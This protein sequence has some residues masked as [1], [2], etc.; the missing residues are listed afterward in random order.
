LP[1]F[2]YTQP[3][4]VA[5]QKP[6]IKPSLSTTIKNGKYE[7]LLAYIQQGGRVKGIA[8]NKTQIGELNES[9]MII[10]IFLKLLAM[11]A[12][13]EPVIHDHFLDSWLP[14]PQ[15]DNILRRN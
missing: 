4:Q 1:F 9:N 12:P 5:Q 13:Y 10:H 8:D 15:Q 3:S 7:E 14:V 11:R 2:Y 6:E